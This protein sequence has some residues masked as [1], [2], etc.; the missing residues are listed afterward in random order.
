MTYHTL[1]DMR[2]AISGQN[3]KGVWRMPRSELE[4]H[5]SRLGLKLNEKKGQPPTKGG[6]K[7]PA[8][9]TAKK[10]PKIPAKVAEKVANNAAEEVAPKKTAPA[11]LFLHKVTKKA[12]GT[13][14]FTKENPR[15]STRERKKRV[16]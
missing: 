13:P 2:R 11:D 5:V 16:L 7:K 3:V 14:L 15:R 12:D 6:A 8:K 4:K 9:K 10:T 1:L